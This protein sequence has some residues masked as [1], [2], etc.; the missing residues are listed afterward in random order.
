MHAKGKIY[1]KV[2]IV[3]RQGT[4]RRHNQTMATTGIRSFG[5]Q[6]YRLAQ[7]RNI[8]GATHSSSD[9]GVMYSYFESATLKYS[10]A[11]IDPGQEFGAAS[12]LPHSVA[13]D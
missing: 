10:G 8:L 12:E 2:Q 6:L 13:A 1:K 3:V 5:R 11:G 7:C 9:L 4:K